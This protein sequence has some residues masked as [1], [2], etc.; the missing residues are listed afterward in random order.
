MVLISAALMMFGGVVVKKV[1][2]DIGKMDA[3]LVVSLS[4]FFSFLQF[5]EID[6]LPPLAKILM[7]PVLLHLLMQLL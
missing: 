3:S 6:L 4:A 5:N 2:S 7:L 1:L